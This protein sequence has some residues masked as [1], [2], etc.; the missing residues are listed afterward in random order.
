MWN[1]WVMGVICLTVK[2]HLLDKRKLVEFWLV[3]NLQIHMWNV[4]SLTIRRQT[5]LICNM[6]CS[7]ENAKHWPVP[8]ANYSLSYAAL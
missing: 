4:L 1:N 7:A 8:V 5:L 2:W 3:P 6:R